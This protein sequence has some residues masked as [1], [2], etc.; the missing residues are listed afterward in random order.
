MNA[1][2]N[3]A[4]RCLVPHL[5]DILKKVMLDSRLQSIAQAP[6]KIADGLLNIEGLTVEDTN[7]CSEDFENDVCF[8]VFRNSLYITDELQNESVAYCCAQGYLL[9]SSLA[10]RVF[11]ESGEKVSLG[12]YLIINS[13]N[14]VKMVLYVQRPGQYWI[15]SGDIEDFSEGLAAL[16]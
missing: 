8:D 5:S 16:E 7:A 12:A 6:I 15:D 11:R 9:Y 2:T 4:F 13:D 14:E 1:I 3:A 10:N